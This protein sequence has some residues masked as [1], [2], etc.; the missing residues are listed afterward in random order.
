M[1]FHNEADL[2]DYDEQEFDQEDNTASIISTNNNSL[3]NTDRQQSPVTEGNYNN[4]PPSVPRAH[5][6]GSVD[7]VSA[8]EAMKEML[9]GCSTDDNPQ[10]S[11]ITDSMDSFINNMLTVS[12]M[13]G[14]PANECVAK[15]V[16]NQLARDFS[17]LREGTRMIEGGPSEANKVIEKMKDNLHTPS[18]IQCLKTCTINACVYKTMT[19]LA[20]RCN[21]HGQ[22]AEQA[23]CKTITAQSKIMSDLLK[24]KEHIRPEG[25]NQ[26]QGI[27]KQVG[28][29]VELLAFGRARVNESRRSLILANINS[30]YR[31]IGN[32]TKPEDGLLFGKELAE[33]MREVEDSN[34]LAQKLARPEISNAAGKA[35]FLGRGRGRFQRRHP[36]KQQAPQTQQW[37][38]KPEGP[39]YRGRG[40]R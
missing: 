3:L 2:L 6:H 39:R 13:E 28:D 15:F 11:C 26:L 27:L 7:P 31:P 5:G 16:N 29:S 4:D 25:M 38:Y 12:N 32:K 37:P 18:N 9:A 36:Y 10:I 40:R 20:K 23:T 34:K 8:D 14:P 33:A 24:L 35:H 17:E 21:L 30:N 1:E 19:P 22:L